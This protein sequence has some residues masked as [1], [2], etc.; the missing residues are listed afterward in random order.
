MYAPGETTNPTCYPGDTN[1]SVYPPLTTTL[2]T[3]TA[4][5]M[6][7]S[8][9]RFAYD[10]ANY[11]NL[12][13]ASDGALTVSSTNSATTTLANKISFLSN[14]Y[15][16]TIA[17]G[18]WNGVT[19]AIAYGGT[20]STTIA[21]N[22]SIIYSDGAK[23]NASAVGVSG[24]ILQSGGSGVP[25]WVTTTTMGFVNLQGATSG[26]Q[27]IGNFNIS[28]TGLFGTKVGINTTTPAYA[29][30]VSGTTYTADLIAKGGGFVD[31]RAY[32]AT[33]DGTGDSTAAFQAAIN[34]AYLDPVSS[35]GGAV[36]IPAG[37]YII[38]STLTISNPR[39]HIY[40][41]GINASVISFR[42]ASAGLSLFKFST[43]VDSVLF[44]NSLR[45]IGI[46]GTGSL[47]KIGIELV[48]TSYMDIENVSL[49]YMNGN[50]SI[51]IKLR[52]REMTLLRNISVGADKPLVISDNP[53]H[54]IDVDHLHVE[55]ATFTASGTNPN[56]T[57]DSGVNLSNVTFDGYQAWMLGGYGLYWKDTSTVMTSINLVLKN[58]RW[59][60]STYASGYLFDIEHNLTL[61]NLVMENVYGGLSTNGI[62]L[63]NIHW[64]TL[65]NYMYVDTAKTALD[66][67]TTTL[68]LVLKNVFFQAGST[69]TFGGLTTIMDTSRYSSGTGTTTPF[70]VYDVPW[71]TSVNSFY[72]LS[73]NTTTLLAS[74]GVQATSSLNPF[75]ILTSTA[76]ASSMFTIL[77]NGNVGIN[78]SS[79][80]ASLALQG[81]AGINPFSI[82]S[83]TGS[84]LLNVLQN[85][86]VGIGV[87][88]PATKLSIISA[89]SMANGGND[90]IFTFDASGNY[91]NG[92]ANTQSSLSAD[93]NIMAFWVG[94]STLTGQTR[95]MSLFGGGSVSIGTSSPL[96]RLTLQGSGTQNPF[97]IVSS[98]A[99]ATSMFTV[100]TNG[101]VGI[102]S[103]SPIATFALQG[104]G[105]TNP[106]EIASSTGASLFRILQN[107]YVGVNSS[108]P[109]SVFA[110]SG[111]TT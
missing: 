60:Q 48:D 29:L 46:L 34:A 72:R 33:N 70:A 12:T 23:Y 32:G 93:G 43:G 100:L 85:G 74:L 50:D 75:S 16:N 10:S 24:Q 87:T 6:G 98:S 36:Y 101:N 77:T 103:S 88:A 2:T 66:V 20:N 97:S 90:L 38:T 35:L 79:P 65:E 22:G 82:N 95:V 84:A 26:T 13:V 110:V 99:S 37:T 19:I 17:S 69:S 54:T 44:Q 58:I 64:A 21:A 15:F 41:A 11:T 4:I 104:A 76:A 53:N 108:T 83:S 30:T 56:V 105:G 59:E 45:D 62:K 9:L 1:C 7:T 55:N 94:D 71:A 68:S 63:R 81:T 31:V 67:N 96:A 89:N 25:V 28:G 42:P 78:S 40:G 73:I 86:N 51:G 14:A 39:I 49:L 3:S 5:I 47:Q 111:T 27:Q 8:S 57:I 91:R 18:T 52:G 106:F 61:Q 107:G 109:S 80:I 92:I 102:N